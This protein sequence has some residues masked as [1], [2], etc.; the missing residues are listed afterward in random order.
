MRE[1]VHGLSGP[2][3]AIA[4][5]TRECTGGRLRRSVPATSIMAAL[6]RL[7][8]PPAT[9]RWRESIELLARTRA[10]ALPALVLTGHDDI[11]QASTELHYPRRSPWV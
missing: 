5:I 2:G 4:G 1:R 3:C 9:E 6:T 7:F 8:A 11:D 10:R